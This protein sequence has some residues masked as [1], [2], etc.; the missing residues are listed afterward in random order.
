M[1]YLLMWI[2]AITIGILLF[3]EYFW[4]NIIIMF[5]LHIVNHKRCGEFAKYAMTNFLP[6]IAAQVISFS[7]GDHLSRAYS[8]WIV[9]LLERSCVPIPEKL[10]DEIP[11]VMALLLFVVMETFSIWCV[12]VPIRPNHSLFMRNILRKKSFQTFSIQLSSMLDRLDKETQWDTKNFIPLNA[13]VDI[14]CDNKTK[15]KTENLLQALQQSPG[16]NNISLVIGEPGSGKSVAMRG[17]CNELLK[18]CRRTRRIPLYINLKNWNKN[19]KWKP[20]PS[21]IDLKKFILD[22][23]K[24][25]DVSKF[26]QKNFEDIMANGGWFFIFDSYDEI[27]F[28]ANKSL[29]YNSQVSNVIYD[30]LI[31]NGGVLS[32]RPFRSPDTDPKRVRNHF[33]ILPFNEGQLIQFFRRDVGLSKADCMDVFANYPE[34]VDLARTP[35]LASLVRQYYTEK[36]KWPCNQEELYQKLMTTRVQK[37]IADSN[38][39]SG[40]TPELIKTMTATLAYK[41]METESSHSF[42]TWDEVY[43]ALPNYS[44]LQVDD[45][46]ELLETAKICKLN[47]AD[48]NTITFVHRRFMEFF[49]TQSDQFKQRPMQDF[50]SNIKEMGSYYDVLALYGE[51]CEDDKADVLAKECAQVITKKDNVFQNIRKE[52][53]R[54]AINSL[55]FLFNAFCHRSDTVKPYITSISE[56]IMKALEDNCQDNACL[57]VFAT[58]VPILS[59][60]YQEDIL[61]ALL[62]YKYKWISQY[63]GRIFYRGN[64]NSETLLLAYIENLNTYRDLLFLRDLP[65]LLFMFAK[66]KSLKQYCFF[67]VMDI[68]LSAA[69]TTVLIGYTVYRLFSG[70]L[71]FTLQDPMTWMAWYQGLPLS[72]Q[73]FWVAWTVWILLYVVWISS[74]TSYSHAFLVM[75]I[76]ITSIV[77]DLT[78]P[79]RLAIPFLV[80]WLCLHGLPQMVTLKLKFRNTKEKWRALSGFILKIT[81]CTLFLAIILVGID[82]FSE[83]SFDLGWYGVLLLLFITCI[84]F[85]PVRMLLDAIRL[86]TALKEL[87]TLDGTLPRYKLEQILRGI[88][89]KQ[90]RA[91]LITQLSRMNIQLTEEWE[92]VS[93]PVIGVESADQLLTALDTKDLSVVHW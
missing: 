38:K 44:H 57:A 40:L 45:A 31:S 56:K 51:I 65:V 86:R 62:N 54:H 52:N 55:N 12:D 58:V 28:L 13:E 26:L 64:K 18:K 67:R 9:P 5:V 81:A 89:R 70:Q 50:L 53:C 79:I 36:Q 93:R 78:L 24:Q 75:S 46:I 66:E 87:K 63:L 15:H 11:F 10:E 1:Q 16:K 49:V 8:F 33:R 34:I 14:L 27:P 92:D 23:F 29:A 91:R 35:L 30:F 61:V 72:A 20:Y 43:T 22:S 7:L 32:S 88:R 47:K 6:L 48:Q 83:S 2:V 71:F 73:L 82:R 60:Q 74:I 68:M 3:R 41:I 90:L 37:A 17:L 59:Q 39:Q 80:Y 25:F 21:P 42:L 84:F 69:A 76:T 77:T 4:I 19:W 85:N